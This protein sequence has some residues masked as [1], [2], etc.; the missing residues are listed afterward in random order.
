MPNWLRKQSEPNLV[1]GTGVLPKDKCV[2]GIGIDERDEAFILAHIA[3]GYE[4]H[5]AKIVVSLITGEA[6]KDI[7]A[8]IKTNCSETGANS[9]LFSEAVLEFSGEAQKKFEDS[10]I[11][12]RP[13]E[14]GIE[15]EE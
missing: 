10:D 11:Y 3:P 15:L 13:S 2:I 5:A 8:S 4:R 7:L 1:D 6:T 12:I 14:V 9:R